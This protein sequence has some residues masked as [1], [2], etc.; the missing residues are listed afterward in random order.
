MNVAVLGIGAAGREMARLCARGGS[1]VSIHAGDPSAAMDAIDTIERHLERADVRGVALDATTGLAAAVSDADLVVETTI[2][3]AEQLGRRFAELEPL[4]DRET[5]V[6]TSRGSLSVTT[7]ASALD[8]PG[9]ALGLRVHPDGTDVVELVATEATTESTRDR[10]A[11]FVEGLGATPLFVGDTPGPVSGR[12]VVALEVEAMRLLEAGAAGVETVDELLVTG[13]DHAVGPLERADRVGL[14][15]RLDLLEYLAS[16]V[17]DR[18]DP[19]DVLV[20]RVAVGKTGR[21][22]GEGFYTWQGDEPTR[23]AVDGPRFEQSR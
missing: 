16:E 13:Y 10:A 17:G 8:S 11:S 1:E 6:A 19:P 15:R 18:Y 9:R 22:A 2:D 3:D 12:L 4:L 14:D 21:H 7:A 20:E 23:P 5:L